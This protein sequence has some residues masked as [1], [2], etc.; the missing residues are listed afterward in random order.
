MKKLLFFSL[1]LQT[2]PLSY[3]MDI[4]EL[5]AGDLRSPDV[6][7][8][9]LIELIKS[10]SATNRAQKQALARIQNILKETGH[11]CKLLG[12]TQLQ[13]SM[14]DKNVQLTPSKL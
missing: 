10:L 12:Q 3:A 6:H 4:I 5:P 1:I 14:H 8:V 7:T 2:C 9:V 11:A 13:V